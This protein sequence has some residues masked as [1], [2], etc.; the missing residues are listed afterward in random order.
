VQSRAKL[1]RRLA[2]GGTQRLPSSRTGG[3]RPIAKSE[4]AQGFREGQTILLGSLGV[5]EEDEIIAPP[6]V[7]RTA[8]TDLEARAWKI[9]QF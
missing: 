2:A 9:D 6:N 1:E 4:Q 7:K 5:M 3:S 8:I